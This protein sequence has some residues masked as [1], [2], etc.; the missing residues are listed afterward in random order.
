MKIRLIL[1]SVFS[2]L[3]LLS[4]GKEEKKADTSK[5][6]PKSMVE[7]KKADDGKG[8]GDTKSVKTK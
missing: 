5:P 2:M 7:E 3:L 1:I 4:C 8:F 6:A